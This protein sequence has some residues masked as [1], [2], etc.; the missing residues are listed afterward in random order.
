MR[1]EIRNT[2]VEPRN[3]G[4]WS[5][6]CGRVSA[7]LRRPFV[8]S[9][10]VAGALSTD[11]ESGAIRP[12]ALSVSLVTSIEENNSVQSTQ[13]LR[14]SRDCHIEQD[15]CV[16]FCCTTMVFFPTDTNLLSVIRRAY[17]LGRMRNKNWSC[18]S[19]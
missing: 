13:Q 15:A 12:A 8:K 4:S 2:N 1:L 18:S 6:R 9:E 14:P 7:V 19:S 16:E 10:L 5:G 11:S 3:Y 17:A